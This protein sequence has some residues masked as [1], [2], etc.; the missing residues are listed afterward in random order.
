MNA[1]KQPEQGEFITLDGQE[2]TA[3]TPPNASDCRIAG[4]TCVF[5]NATEDRVCQRPD[6]VPRCVS[7]RIV[8]FI[9]RSAYAELRLLGAV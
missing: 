3:V 5:F 2:L 1:P 6:S 8:I 9:G 4:I 7:P